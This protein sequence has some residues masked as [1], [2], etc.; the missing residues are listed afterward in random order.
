MF[1]V[2]HLD[3]AK[4]YLRCCICCNDNIRMLQAYVFK[5]FI[6]IFQVFHLDVTKV[7]LDVANA[8]MSQEYVLS[9]SGVSYVCCTCF[10]W[11]LHMFCNGY[12][13]MFLS[14]LRCLQVFQTY[15]VAIV[16]T[17]SDVCCKCFILMLHR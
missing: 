10:I 12:T 17:D 2:F 14:V 4:V 11:M 1:Q 3:V 13:H 8:R 9:V 15:V 16:L 5:C 7:D 6:C